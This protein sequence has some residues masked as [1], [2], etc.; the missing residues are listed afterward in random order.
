M[1]DN[2][3]FCISVEGISKIEGHA[4]LDVKVK[5][6]KVIDA[7]LRINEN[8]RFNTL[9]TI[10]KPALAV[11]QIVS[12]IC[13]TCSV[14]HLL[15]C[16]KCVEN[17]LGFEP[18]KQTIKLR[19]LMLYGLNIRDHAMHL[20]FFSLPDIFGKDS[21]LDFADTGKEHDLLHKALAIKTAGNNLSVLIGGRAVHPPNILVGGFSKILTPDEAKKMVKELKSIRPFV[22]EF[23]DIFYKSDFEFITETTFIALR[24]DRFSYLEGDLISS[25]GTRIE[26]ND[27]LEHLNKFVLPYSQAAGFSFKGKP[28][29]VG[30][31]ARMNLNK[32]ALH[33]KTQVSAAKYLDV[34]PSDNM[35]HNNLAQAIEILHAIDS[36]IQSLEENEFKVESRP[37]IVP[38]KSHGIGVI[39]APRGTLYYNLRIDDAGKIEWADLVIPTAQNQIKIDKDIGIL[40]QQKLD[41]KMSRDKIPFE[42][43]KL[44]RAYDP[45]MSC[46]THFLK[47]NW[48]EE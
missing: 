47:V 20:F 27:L 43:E 3:E 39:E 32:D 48:K 2:E 16:I 9:A 24:N 13:G 38:K 40:V 21:V 25:D 35:F 5:K 7:K 28:Y 19:D 44:I 6:G 12:R 8:K 15:C 1:H 31:L 4:S 10:G 45:C 34:F 37:A 42:L 36:S 46:A 33:P 11:H 18:S 41:K 23:I 30:A 17:A 29:T 22:L 14:A 26:E